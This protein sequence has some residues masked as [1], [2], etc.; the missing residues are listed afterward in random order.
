MICFDGEQDYLELV[1]V[2]PNGNVAIF[3]AKIACSIHRYSTRDNSHDLDQI[4]RCTLEFRLPYSWSSARERA[5]TYYQHLVG[6][7]DYQSISSI[8]HGPVY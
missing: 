4:T 2:F 6:C 1:K 3:D 5:E 7:E 8:L